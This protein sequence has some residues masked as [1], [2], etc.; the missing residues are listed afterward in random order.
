MVLVHLVDRLVVR[1]GQF[2][3]SR[4]RM[5]NYAGGRAGDRGRNKKK[6]RT[7]DFPPKTFDPASESC[8]SLTP[9]S[10]PAGFLTHLPPN[11]RA[12]TWWPKQMPTRRRSGY[13]AGSEAVKAVSVAIQGRG[14][15]A[16]AASHGVSGCSGRG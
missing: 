2:M 3:E 14:S 8:K 9:T 16:E 5:A 6:R 12:T 11:A 4:S 15:W 1:T 10:H 13:K 7:K